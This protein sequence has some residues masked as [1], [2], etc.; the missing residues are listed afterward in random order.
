MPSSQKNTDTSCETEVDD[1]FDIG[2]IETPK[3]LAT[4]SRK[5][6]YI[7]FRTSY[8]DIE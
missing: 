8:L 2:R 5:K 3:S 7:L 4:E 6:R 1:F